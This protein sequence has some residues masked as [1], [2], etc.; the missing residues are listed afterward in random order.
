DVIE[1][2]ARE[3][4]TTTPA[5]IRSL[6]GGEH[7]ENGAMFY[8]TLVC[9]PALTGA[10]RHRGGGFFR[11][12]GSWQDQLVDEAVLGRPDLLAGREVRTF[13][14]SRLGEIL[15][16]EQP[17]V[18][19]LIVWNSNPLVI[20]PNAER[21]REGMARDDLFTVVHEQFLTDTAQYADIVLPATTHIESV[22]V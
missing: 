18:R 6:I 7:H 3:Y 20:V 15:L 17:P 22:D 12:V 21:A 10:W 5:A 16:D 11:S 2:F 1:A 14:M 13:N 9:L 4:A 19:A 8:R